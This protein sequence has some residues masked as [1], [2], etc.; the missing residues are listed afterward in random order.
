MNER[1]LVTGAG[2]FIGSHLVELLVSEGCKVRAFVRYNSGNRWGMLEQLQAAVMNEVE[3]VTGD[4]RDGETVERA[5]AG[6]ARVFHLGALIAIPYSYL[7]PDDVV[8]T[9]VLG[10]QNVLNA[11][12]KNSSLE[13]LIHTSTSEVYGTAQ[14][15]PIDEAHPL[16]AQSPYAA[17][18]I[19]A[20]KVVESYHLSYGLP[21][22]TIRPFNAFGPRQSAR[23]IIPTI[24]TQVLAGG[25]LKLGT[26]E[27]RR[28]FTF[29]QDTARAFWLAS[30]AE[31]VEGL[32]LNV[33]TGKDVTIRELLD[34][35]FAQLDR[36]VDVQL[37]EN[38]VRPK[39]SEVEVLQCNADL[40]RR[41][42]GWVPRQTLE[43]GLELTANWFV[44]HQNLFRAELYNV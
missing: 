38:R 1:V 17:S 40:A 19:A 18:K 26:L 22:V 37:D 41:S 29:V 23:A 11:C 31:G 21:A 4:L 25:S 43:Q 35:I 34:I 8:A 24:L 10:T 3:V 12:R 15:T 36:C 2:G 16:Q 5:I 6:C 14:Y 42:L 39:G 27:T 30:E 13:R 20:D 28:D 32:V 9:N 44:A 7:S 33:G